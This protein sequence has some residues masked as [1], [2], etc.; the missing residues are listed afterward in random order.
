MGSPVLTFMLLVSSTGSAIES[1]Q[2]SASRRPAAPFVF[3]A[4]AP[5]VLK[6]IRAAEAGDARLFNAQLSDQ[7]VG[8]KP[9]MSLIDLRPKCFLIAVTQDTSIMVTAKWT[10]RAD[11]VDAVATRSF[12]ISQGRI[13]A[14]TGEPVTEYHFVR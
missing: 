11:K 14:I 13:A 4:A 5:I 8:S 12:L 7:V 6:A 3:G 10:C 2:H 1:P 9:R